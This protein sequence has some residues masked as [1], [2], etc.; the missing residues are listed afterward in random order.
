MDWIPESYPPTGGLA[1]AGFYKLLG[2][3]RLDPLTVLVRETAQNSWDARLENGNPVRFTIAGCEHTPAERSALL[4]KIFVDA[5]KAHGTRIH[6]ALTASELFGLYIS[7]RNTKGLSGPLSAAEADPDD[8]YDWVDFVL[9][10]GKANTQGHTGGTYGFGKTISYVVS[11]AN[12]VVIYSR[13]RYRGAHESR[14]IAC[15]IGEEFSCQKRLY[16]GRHWWGVNVSDSPQPVVG[17]EADELATQIGMPTF[18]DGETGTNILIVA[19]DFGGRRPDQAMRFIAESALWHLWPKMLERSGTL[20][21]AVSVTWN[22]TSV[23]IPR[24]E[25]R[26]PLHGFIQTFRAIVERTDADSL[27]PGLRVEEIR[28]SRPK[29]L[30]GMLATVPM[31]HRPRAVVDDG[32]NPDDSESPQP[33]SPIAGPCHHVALLRTPELV[34]DYLEGPPAPEGGMEWAGVFRANDEYDAHFAAA[35]PPTHDSWI[36]SLLP[37]SPGRTIVNVGLR[38]IRNALDRRWGKR[39][40]RHTTDSTSTALIADQLA[41]LVRSVEAQGLG[42]HEKPRSGGRATG[43]KPKIDIVYTAPIVLGDGYGTLARVRITPAPKKH[44]TKLHIDVAAAL[45]GSS[46]DP[47]LDPDLTLVEAR[48]GGEPRPLDG[49]RCVVDIDSAKTVEVDL[50]VRRDE[51]TTVLFDLQAESD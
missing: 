13:T 48:V 44:S 41:H 19:P 15:A 9:N 36:P 27:P 25:D 38:E 35:E 18:A 5:K 3:P 21:M 29:A 34:I 11:Q 46:A 2:R 47:D 1:A 14:L 16:T 51:E 6:D 33:A 42:R 7:D 49:Q 37:K 12:A 31:V 45:D 23:P 50:I 22:G 43:A 4:D 39:E 32:S 17:G 30:V 40:N 20:P 24:P 28:S 8:T 10:A 26:P